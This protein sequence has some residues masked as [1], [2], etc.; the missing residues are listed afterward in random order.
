MGRRK[1]EIQPIT[2]ERNRSVTFQKRKNG[3][4][5]KAY[6][7]G[8]LCSVDVAVILFEQRPGHPPKLYQYGSSDIREI[9]QRQ[10]RHDGENDTRGPA[11]FTGGAAGGKNDD[12]DDGD[13]GDGDG[14]DD[15]EDVGPP[16]T[17]LPSRSKRRGDGQ[18]KPTAS[19]ILQPD[20]DYRIASVPSHMPLGPPQPHLP[21]PSHSTFGLSSSMHHPHQR[22]QHP[23][24]SDRLRPMDQY[25]DS[26]HQSKRPRLDVLTV[27]QQQQH[28][29]TYG[30]RGGSQSSMSS[31]I[32]SGRGGDYSYHPS[33]QGPPSSHQYS[34][35]YAFPSSG[36]LPSHSHPYPV[37]S[38]GPPPPFISL[39]PQQAEFSFP[40][41]PPPGS[42]LPSSSSASRSGSRRDSGGSY[43]TSRSGPGVYGSE[44]G[45]GNQSVN[46]MYAPSP[47]PGSRPGGGAGP[48]EQNAGE[49]LPDIFSSAS[50]ARGRGTEWPGHSSSGSN[51]GRAES[52][53]VNPTSPAPANEEDAPVG[54]NSNASDV[55][56]D[57]LSP[58][59]ATARV[60][61]PTPAKDN[62]NVSH[63]TISSASTPARQAQTHVT[64]DG[65][66]GDT[67]GKASAAA[68]GLFRMGPRGQDAE[69]HGAEEMEDQQE[70][71]DG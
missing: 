44:N 32:T 60:S 31:P 54:K 37:S 62:G 30:N 63:R 36:S 71:G 70:S 40:P 33:F 69:T 66:N 10:L 13:D 58:Q 21:S 22:Q 55:W 26:Q 57:F 5:K 23:I 14:E 20:L 27:P 38:P 4:F 3:L 53:E 49:L 43:P 8:V 18:H 39:N 11:E 56:L 50:A 47:G 29:Q 67:G 2:H 35:Q 12:D 52:G 41:P 7:L 24:S 25:Q 51:G 15:G 9:I 28:H 6:E 46:G 64:E 48:S 34:P 42:V 1:I 65:V 16:P 19:G 45:N 17:K 59:T 61:S 68:L